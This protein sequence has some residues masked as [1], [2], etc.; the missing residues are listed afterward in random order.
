MARIYATFR[1]RRDLLTSPNEY[2]IEQRVML[3]SGT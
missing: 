2:Y 1:K 3:I